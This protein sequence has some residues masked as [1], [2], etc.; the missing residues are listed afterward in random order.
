M[1]VMI[2]GFF[3]LHDK[4]FNEWS[5]YRAMSYVLKLIELLHVLILIGV[6]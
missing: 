1:L 2:V 5:L 6:Q 3:F 4:Y